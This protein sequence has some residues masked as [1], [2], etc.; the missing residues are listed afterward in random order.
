M[1]RKQEANSWNGPVSTTCAAFLIPLAELDEGFLCWALGDTATRRPFSMRPNR[2]LL[3]LGPRDETGPRQLI[4]SGSG[5][6]WPT[7]LRFSLGWHG[8]HTESLMTQGK[9]F[10]GIIVIC[11]D[12]CPSSCWILSLW[13][14]F[15]L[16][17]FQ[18]KR[19]P[20]RVSRYTKT[21]RVAALLQNL[22]VVPALKRPWGG[23]RERR[24][25]TKTP[26]RGGPMMLP[27]KSMC[28]ECT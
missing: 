2:F 7:L 1:P 11:L 17:G 19:L 20:R 10:N 25:K 4:R 24:Q 16:V 27:I 22:L 15:S 9:C 12:S 5:L 21:K 13:R 8:P 28:M 26:T 14:P 18:K 23:G 3:E 6:A